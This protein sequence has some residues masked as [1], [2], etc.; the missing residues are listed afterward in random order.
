MTDRLPAIDSTLPVGQRFPVV[1]RDEIIAIAASGVSKTSIGLGNVDNTADA[2]KPVSGPQQTALNAKLDKTST[3]G[4]TYIT[5]LSGAQALMAYSTLADDWTL[6]RR[7]GGGALRVGAATDPTH[8]VTLAQLTAATSGGIADGAVTTPKLADGAVTTEKIADGTIATGDLADSSVTSAKIADGTIVNADIAA[9]AAIAGTK[10]ANGGVG[11]TQLASNAVTTV[12]ILDA[13][14]TTAKIADA[15]VTLAKLAA[16]SVDSSKIV[17]GSVA[18]A[19]LVTAVQTSL[20]KADSSLQNVAGTTGIWMG[21]MGS[22]PASGT[23]GV[24]YVVTG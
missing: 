17:N 15:N 5:D 1:V 23:A 7:E 18:L 19:D 3:P 24:L 4:Q 14:V 22:L 10:L 2:D 20:G 12:K 13:N 9:A 11:A 16:D 6:A 21:A 8:A